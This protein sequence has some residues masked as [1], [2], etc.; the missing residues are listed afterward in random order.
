MQ[1]NND[2]RDAKDA[3]EAAQ[4]ALADCRQAGG[5]F[6]LV[7]NT[8]DDD[9][10][11]VSNTDDDDALG[12]LL[13]SACAAIEAGRA[14]CSLLGSMAQA[15]ID[16]IEASLAAA[17]CNRRMRRDG[18]PCGTLQQ[19]FNAAQA[20]FTIAEVSKNTL[21]NPSGD[22]ASSIASAMAVVAVGLACAF[23]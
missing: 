4:E 22:S 10:P 20:Q 7:S 6:P 13:D 2:C 15:C 5:G 18:D 17:N 1:R 16:G 23:Y 14:Q 3:L 12:G 19:A 9:T 11:L 8:D 21:D